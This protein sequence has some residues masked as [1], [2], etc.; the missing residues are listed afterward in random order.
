MA[1]QFRHA[2]CNEVF[3]NWDFTESCKSIRA[4]GYAGIEI[5]PFT[6]A[7]DPGSIPVPKRQEYRS[8]ISS[9]GLEFAGLHWLMVSPKGLH[10]TTPDKALRD[11]SWA[12]V[13]KLVDLCGDLG[14]GIMVFGSPKQ[15]ATTEGASVHDARNRYRDGLAEVAPQAHQRGVTIL[16]EALPLQECDVVTSLEEAVG[17]VREINQPAIRTMFDTHNAVNETERHAALVDRYFDYI[18]HVHVNEMDGRH[19]GTGEYDFKP[20]LDVL[21]RRSYRGWVSLEVFD[22]KPG[23]DTIARESIDYLSGEIRKLA[24]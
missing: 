5:A 7:E 24:A 18:R 11:R 3:E 1:Y 23:A 4:A 19:P 9:E 17:L 14:G 12:H 2:I 10:V 21:R 16:I 6:L 15:R 13:R 22:F 8:I 20:V